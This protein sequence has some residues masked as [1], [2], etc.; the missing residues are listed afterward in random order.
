MASQLEPLLGPAA[1]FF[2]AFGLLAAGITSSVTAPLAA[3]YATAGAVGWRGDLSDPKFKAV[4]AVIILVGVTFAIIGSSPTQ[5]IV[6]AQAANGLILPIVAVFLLVV[7]NRRD[8]LG[9]H[10]NSTGANIVGGIVVLIAIGL[11]I[12]S[13]LSAF[14]VL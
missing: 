10:V 14:G 8:L 3:A 4:W 6:F 12:R 5:A 13:L 1:K 9:D 11:G 2:F 7:M